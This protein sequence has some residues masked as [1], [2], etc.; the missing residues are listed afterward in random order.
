[1][2]NGTAARAGI[3]ISACIFATALAGCV[4]FSPI[5]DLQTATASGTPFEQAL[6][7]DY[8]YIAR[9]FGDMGQAAYTS[10]DQD[11]SYSLN[12]KDNDVAALANRFAAKALQLSKGEVVDPEPSR[13][14]ASHGLRDRLVRAI[15]TAQDA[16]PR[17]AARAQADWDCWRLNLTVPAMANAAAQ[18]KR[19]FDISL[20]RVE[21]EAKQ[22]AEAEEAAKKAS[23]GKPKQPT[24]DSDTATP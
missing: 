23:A 21:S 4:N 18:C 5:D 13:D 6:F 22:V 15:T 20:T 9:S 12:A 17:D 1:M 7:V 2:V 16:Y 19:S 3:T 8:A 11:A 24:D 14:V 10:F